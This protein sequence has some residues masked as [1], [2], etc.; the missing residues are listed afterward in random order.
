MENFYV[1][2]RAMAIV[3]HP[4]DIEFS[5]AGTLARWAKHGCLTSY[6]ICTSGEVGI[7]ETG[8]A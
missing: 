7:A 1:P 5:C 4:D 8:M 6:V 3:A 2:K